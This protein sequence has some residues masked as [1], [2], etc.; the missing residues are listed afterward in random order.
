[1]KQRTGAILV[2]YTITAMAILGIF[3]A[4]SYQRA[5]AYRLYLTA[6]YQHAFGEL[7]TSMEEMDAALQKSVYAT[8]PSVASAVCTEVFGKA[9]TAQMTL[10]VLPFSTQE[11]EQTASFISKV[12]D[13]SHALSRSTAAGK[14]FSDEELESLKSLSETATLLTQNLNDVQ[15]EI[16]AGNLTMDDLVR[17]EKTIDTREEDAVS[18]PTNLSGSM[19]QI[20]QEF[21]EVPSLIYDGPF[22]EH[23][24]DSKLAMLEGKEM[25]D[26]AAAAEAAAKFLNIDA[27]Q[28]TVTGTTNGNLPCYQCTAWVGKTEYNLMVTTVG[29]EILSV[30][31]DNQPKNAKLTAEE[32]MDTAKHFLEKRGYE[33]LK[34]SYYM[35][36]DQILTA[37][38]AYEQD[39]VICYSDLIKVGISLE[40]G[41][42]T[43]FESRGYLTAH[44]TRE[45]SDNLV[46][47][48]KAREMVSGDLKILSEN[49]TLI[50]S[51]GQNETLCYEFKCRTD[52]EQHYIIYV[53][54]ETGNQE[55]ILIL[56]EDENG[57]LTM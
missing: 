17:G 23:L 5:E 14:T 2:A 40:D 43:G 13:Y 53:N 37:N 38:F 21:P 44:R 1:M 12:G 6:N 28:V 22:S 41:S 35:T 19:K 54:A 16:N 50:P 46:G 8:S 9:M 26:E 45:F 47:V 11:L 48:D 49:L 51:D 24:D 29:G 15:H 10:G 4:V 32:A 36:S 25:V 57:T 7:V 42:L 55:K 27:R 52:N 20:E 18:V 34:E 33:S 30:V 56:L 31:S 39:G 3:S